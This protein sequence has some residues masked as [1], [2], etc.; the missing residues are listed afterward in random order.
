MLASLPTPSFFPTYRHDYNSVLSL[1]M[2]WATV[3]AVTYLV[4]YYTLLPSA[5]VRFSA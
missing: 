5:A 2:N 4:Y 1:E 3:Q